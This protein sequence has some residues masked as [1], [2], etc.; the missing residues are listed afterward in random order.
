MA[1]FGDQFVIDL[2]K[3][4]YLK[5]EASWG[6]VDSDSIFPSNWLK[7]PR[8]KENNHVPQSKVK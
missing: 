4:K 1:V 6:I 3:N 8:A 2:Y 5:V 7:I